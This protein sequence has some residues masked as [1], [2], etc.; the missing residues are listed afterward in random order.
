M[1]CLEGLCHEVSKRKL[2]GS[3][4]RAFVP[5]LFLGLGVISESPDSA[6]VEALTDGTRD[7][8]I[9]PYRKL[10]KGRTENLVINRADSK[11]EAGRDEIS[12][13]GVSFCLIE[14]LR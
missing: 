7:L 5:L 6:Y 14:W 13:G 8:T 9:W 10:A 3:I 11:G 4:R 2:A 12:E 1:R